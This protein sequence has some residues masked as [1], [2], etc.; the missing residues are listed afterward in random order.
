M[1]L[2]E[3]HRQNPQIQERHSHVLIIQFPYASLSIFLLKIHSKDRSPE[4][5]VKVSSYV[6]SN[7]NQILTQEIINR[8]TF[9]IIDFPN[10][11]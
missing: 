7:F 8:N 4:T 10:L 1:K 9:N 2:S 5:R 11:V 6:R 3:F